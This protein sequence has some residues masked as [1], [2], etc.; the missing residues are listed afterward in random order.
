MGYL[1]GDGAVDPP[2]DPGD[3]PSQGFDGRAHGR[4]VGEHPIRLRQHLEETHARILVHQ[5]SLPYHLRR[6]IG[7]RL[8][9]LLPRLG[10]GEQRGF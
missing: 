3:R 2:T 10:H 7:L 9:Q 6:I 8:G 5:G 4:E 1:L